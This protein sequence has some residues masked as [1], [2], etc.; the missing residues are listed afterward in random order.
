MSTRSL[1]LLSWIWAGLADRVNNCQFV[2][3]N[4]CSLWRTHWPSSIIWTIRQVG[5][6]SRKSYCYYVLNYRTAKTFEW[7]AEKKATKDQN[8]I[9]KGCSIGWTRLFIL[10][11]IHFGTADNRSGSCKFFPCVQFEWSLADEGVHEWGKFG[12]ELAT[13]FN[14]AN[15]NHAG[16]QQEV[17][18]LSSYFVLGEAPGRV[19]S[20]DRN[21]NPNGYYDQI[22]LIWGWYPP[23]SISRVGPHYLVIKGS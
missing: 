23:H 10:C 7:V 9:E 13:T 5:C 22:M 16:M 8:W 19:W 20:D 14:V 12:F 11:S 3:P 4:W 2:T 18:I 17:R 1:E 21:H 6:H 15:A